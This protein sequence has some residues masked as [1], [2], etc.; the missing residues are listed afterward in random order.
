VR[1]KIYLILPVH[2]RRTITERFI[3]CLRLQDY[4]NYHLILI[5]DGSTDGTAEMVK[6]RIS[7]V[8]VITGMGDWWW[9][10]ALQQGYLWL[11]SQP[12]GKDDLV[13]LIND[14][15]EFAPDF[16]AKAERCLRHRHNSLVVAGC[17]SRD[18]HELCDFGVTADWSQL[19]FNRASNGDLISCLST[20]GL[21]IRA[22]DF[23][24]LGGFYPKLLPH[25]LSDYEFTYRAYRKGFS[26]VIE[27]ALEV[28]LDTDATGYG[29]VRHD[30]FFVFLKKYFSAK[31]M[32]NPLA[33]TSF[34]LLACPWRWKLCNL[35][36]VW[37]NSIR[38]IAKNAIAGW[39][40]DR[41]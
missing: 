37:R 40:Q 36:R 29:R 31:S 3:E 1:N 11:K 30:S 39:K 35:Y 22:E 21:F 7:S 12:A 10:G 38:F 28:F 41:M 26:L 17:Y 8:T 13:L 18:T 19:T 32:M 15:L 14:D 20:R 2:N 9:G 4:T 27:P 34:V 5:D 16:L 25:Y 23:L 33:W 24:E 6:A